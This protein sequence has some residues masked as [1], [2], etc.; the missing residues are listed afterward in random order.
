MWVGRNFPLSEKLLI[1]LKVKDFEK[2]I[3]KHLTLKVRSPNHQ[4]SNNYKHLFA[5]FQGMLYVASLDTS[6]T[7]AKDCQQ[8]P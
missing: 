7:T 2:G 4:H 3:I 5:G 8:P 6:E 1:S